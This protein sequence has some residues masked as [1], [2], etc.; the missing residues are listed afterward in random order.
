[1]AQLIGN[2]LSSTDDGKMQEKVAS[3]METTQRSEEDVCFALYECDNDLD[4]AVIYLLEQLPEGAFEKSGKKKKNRTQPG[5]TN[6]GTGAADDDW[7]DNAMPQR[8]GDDRSRTRGGPRNNAGGAGGRPVDGQRGPGGGGFRKDGDNKFGGR[9]LDNRGGDRRT[10][11]GGDAGGRGGRGGS[12]GGRGGRGG[13]M[14]PRGMGLRDQQGGAGSGGGGRGGYGRSGYDNG[15]GG[16]GPVEAMDNW[17]NSQANLPPAGQSEMKTDDSWGDWDNEEYTGS[18][19]DTKVFTPSTAGGPAD[20]VTAASI[21][22][23]GGDA[24]SSGAAVTTTS[25]SGASKTPNYSQVCSGAVSGSGPS[26]AAVVSGQ[27]QQQVTSGGAAGGTQYSDLASSGVPATGANA[28]TTTLSAEQSQ[29]FNSLTSQNSSQQAAAAAAAAAAQANAYQVSITLDGERV[30][31][32]ENE[33][34]A[35]IGQKCVHCVF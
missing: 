3:L 12:F 5:S 8:R 20:V 7:N 27:Q 2:G 33:Y 17:D 29:Y 26:V 30:K 10:D 6:N 32:G 15:G 23:G 22:A 31:Q 28:V 1:M 11:R 4:R 14:G 21:V 35:N 34:W 13:R 24:D 25:A 16:G 19:A 18:L 9:S